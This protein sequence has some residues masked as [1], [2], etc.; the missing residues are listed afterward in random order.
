M[1]KFLW[2]L[3]AAFLLVSALQGCQLGNTTTAPTPQDTTGNDP[4]EPPATLTFGA[5]RFSRL[6]Y[7]PH[8]EAFNDLQNGYLLQYVPIEESSY[9]GPGA[10]ARL[11]SAAETA[12]ILP[13]NGETN[14]ASYFLNLQPLVQA[15]AGFDPGGYL[16]GILEACHEGERMVG[17]PLSVSPS[18]IYY[19]PEAFDAVNLPH[20]QPG[21]TW[22]DFLHAASMLPQARGEGYFGFVPN[23]EPLNL[24][25]PVVDVFLEDAAGELDPEGI[26]AAVA[27]YT[28]LAERGAVPASPGEQ[29]WLARD[30]ALI[31]EGKTAMWVD[32]TQN[33]AYWRNTLGGQVAVAPFPVSSRGDPR[34]SS[35]AIAICAGI[36]GGVADRQGAW[37]WLKFLSGRSISHQAFFFPAT[38]EA[39]ADPQTW[40]GLEEHDKEA[41][42]FALEHAWYGTQFQ[43]ALQVIA[44]GLEL[45]LAGQ[46]S[47]EAALSAAGPVNSGEESPAPGLTP[48]AVDTPLPIPP[49]GEVARINYY[50]S[51]WVH[52]STRSMEALA[53]E[54]NQAHPE[55][56]VRITGE[57]P[58][59]QGVSINMVTMAEIVDCFA[60][61]FT[62]LEDWTGSFYSLDEYLLSSPTLHREDYDPSVLEAFRIDGRLYG[63]PASSLPHVIYYHGGRL[64]ELGITGPDLDWS[65]DDF[66]LLAERL[67]GDSAYGFVPYQ[68]DYLGFLLAGRG[69]NWFD[70]ERTPPILP[71]D[72]PEMLIAVGWL[73]EQV[74]AGV[75]APAFGP[76]S[77]GERERFVDSGRASMWNQYAFL[78]SE[79]EG[80]VLP[81]Y[82]V[83]V[84]PVP[85]TP[86]L[87]PA[88][89][90]S[91]LYISRQSEEPAACWQWLS[92]LS[93][94][95]G[96]FSGVP[97]RLPV[98]HSEAWET[99]FTRPGEALS[100]ASVYR[101]A[102][103]RPAFQER[104]DR[105][106]QSW[107]EQ[108]V[109]SAVLG[110][111]LDL[112]LSQ[113][114]AKSSAYQA[115]LENSGSATQ[116]QRL[117]CAREADPTI[118]AP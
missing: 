102:A 86:G 49:A 107:L 85:R 59:G 9:I 29:D 34:G 14:Y 17:L 22:D 7:E 99:V 115:C 3:F 37:A 101:A 82:E 43:H 117:A 104:S 95:P 47:L 112:V 118:V 63:L 26:A 13:G 1:P 4:G 84:A 10:A 110:Q 5:S 113:A 66:I 52:F 93:E 53:S 19:D 83:G 11:A 90:L 42:R 55:I 21:W 106:I 16:P 31:E 24:L 69:V 116:E 80:V 33:L 109:Q 81:N 54:F 58:V 98:A 8:V 56:Q 15:D 103:S 74:K 68:G 28:D 46:A 100:L 38:Q 79:T 75:I 35:P 57:L 67:S 50:G 65:F 71:L 51:P 96:A 91:G 27:W 78:T 97:A 25:G 12:V 114:Q 70:P 64:A 94:Q 72:S 88:P 40:Q 73:V 45:T 61:P 41:V 18:L 62:P 48:V 108:A 36:S 20:P 39:W 76:D 32:S 92:F 87:L 111:D 44:G 105:F 2:V 30:R 23:G 77:S 6:A 89:V 60:W